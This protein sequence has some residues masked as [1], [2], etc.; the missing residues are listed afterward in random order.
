[1]AQTVRWP[2]ES[3]VIR[4]NSLSNTFG[5]VRKYADGSPKSHQGWDF[6]AVP[7]TPCY[8][9]EAGK[10][11]YCG[12]KGDFGLMIVHS[13]TFGGTTYYAAYAHLDSS[14][15]SKNETIEKGRRIGT[16]GKSGNAA[17]LPADDMHLHFETRTTAM[18]GLGLAGRVS[19]IKIYGVCPL[20]TPVLSPFGLLGRTAWIGIQYA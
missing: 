3:N 19:P 14:E 8:A 7:G 11:E 6:F 20:V 10:V 4:R 9:I 15:V 2:L 1:M 12:Q 17:N 13:F 18:P 5:K 16:T